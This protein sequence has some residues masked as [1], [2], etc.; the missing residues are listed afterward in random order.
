MVTGSVDG[1]VEVWNFTTGKLRKD[2]KY[3]A[4]ENFMLMEDA[5]L[6]MD[7]SRD[8][9]MLASASQDG[10][11][12]VWKI[13]T[14]QCLRKY[15]KAHAKGITS[16]SFSKD[17]SQLLTSSFDHSIRIHGLKSGKLLKEFL[18][19]TSFV[20]CA[21]F[22]NDQINILSASSDGTI[23]IWNAKTTECQSTIKSFGLSSTN[24]ITIHSIHIM[25]KI[26]DQFIACNRSNTLVLM[27]LQGQIIRSFTNAK[28]EGGD[29]ICACLSPRGEL[30]YAIGEDK[31][32]YCFIVQS[33]KLEKSLNVRK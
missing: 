13:Q 17:S 28:K 29:M 16:I 14:G 27:N 6:C 32:L 19:H 8:S 24:D 21:V 15:E 23:R 22:T 11:I 26:N 7:F 30:L 4:Q 20:N 3:Q 9:E 31:L 18:G 10:K 1:F 2:L 12:K 5:C 25:P 33:G